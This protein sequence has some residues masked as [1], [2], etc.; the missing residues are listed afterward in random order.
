[1]WFDKLN[2]FYVELK[3]MFPFWSPKFG[4]SNDKRFSKK[5]VSAARRI[6]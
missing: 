4:L 2:L 3:K 6:A 1:M 5:Q